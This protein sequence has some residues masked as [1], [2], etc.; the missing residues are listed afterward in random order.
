MVMNYVCV[1][2]P[3][4]QIFSKKQLYFMWC[5]NCVHAQVLL[6]LLRNAIKFTP[7]HGT[8]T[9]RTSDMLL[10]SDETAH[11]ATP[12]N[13]FCNSATD[14]QAIEA[15]F[16]Y[17]EVVAAPGQQPQHEYERWIRIEVSDTGMGIAPEMMPHLFRAF[18]QEK[19]SHAFGG[20]GLG[21]FISKGMF[22]PHVVCDVCMDEGKCMR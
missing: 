13:A 6:N 1:K 11:T 22:V 17:A 9:M 7:D 18:E 8:I 15:L 2:N 20:L 19:T 3:T 4:I 10:I 14:T 5:I 12:T 21:L 16:P